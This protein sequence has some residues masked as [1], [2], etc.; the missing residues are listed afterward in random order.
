[1]LIKR[2]GIVGRIRHN[3]TKKWIRKLGYPYRKLG[4]FRLYST[5]C[6]VECGISANEHAKPDPP[7]EF[8]FLDNLGNLLCHCDALVTFGDTKMR[9]HQPYEKFPDSD[10]ILHDSFLNVTEKQL[11]YIEI[12]KNDLGMSVHTR[13]AHIVSIVGKQWLKRCMGSR[14][15]VW[16]LSRSEASQVIEKFK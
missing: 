14:P 13:N 5:T 12:L 9:D 10:E 3:T 1:M 11:N 15:D 7:Q 8:N 6:G 16:A 4:A 2:L